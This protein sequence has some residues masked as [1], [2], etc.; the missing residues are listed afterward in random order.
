MKTILFIVLIFIIILSLY[1]HTESTDY[2]KIPTILPPINKTLQSLP[3]NQENCF[4]K[5]KSNLVGNYSQCTNNNIS[6]NNCNCNQN[7]FN[8]DLCD[9]NNV[10]QLKPSFFSNPPNNNLNRV[11]YFNSN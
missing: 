5:L 3:N 11:N 6:T 4:K 10:I 1:I 2:L 7:S 8:Y 9:P